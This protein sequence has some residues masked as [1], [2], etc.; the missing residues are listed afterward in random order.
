MSLCAIYTYSS[1]NNGIRCR[2]KVKQ[3]F[4]NEV[5]KRV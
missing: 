1:R 5:F 2:F 3:I 4:L